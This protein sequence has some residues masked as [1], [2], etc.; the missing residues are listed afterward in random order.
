MTAP[1]ATEGTAVRKQ[2]TGAI[3]VW[4]ADGTPPA[5]DA[6]AYTW[7]GHA[8]GPGV[9]SLLKYVELHGDRL[10]GKYIS[11]IHDLGESGPMGER[12]IDRLALEGGLSYWWLTPFAEQS[13]YKMPIVDAVRLI[14]LDEIVRV[15]P[16]PNLR[17]FSNNA[18]LH[19]AIKRLCLDAGARYE[20]VRVQ[21]PRIPPR[22]R[23]VYRR[24]PEPVQALGVLVRLIHS[25]R[26]LRKASKKLQSPLNH[27]GV[28]FVSYFGNFSNRLQDRGRFQS[29]YWGGLVDLLAKHGIPSLWLEI[30]SKSAA[31][32]TP[33]VACNWLDG[34]NEKPAENGCHMFVESYFSWAAT[35]RVFAQWITLCWRGWRLDNLDE[36]CAKAGHRY[37][38]VLM[39][40]NWRRSLG[41]PDAISNLMALEV[42]CE[43]M[44]CLPHQGRGFYLCENQGWERALIH[45]W[46]KHGHGD[47]IGV[48][49][50]TV[51]FWDLRYFVDARTLN[52]ASQY[53]IPQPNALV[54]NGS[55]A[56]RALEHSGFPRARLIECEALRYEHLSQVSAGSTGARRHGSRREILVLGDYSEIV[57]AKMLRMLETYA[58]VDDRSHRCNY[59][60][61]PHPYS[62]IALDSFP[63][64][65]LKLVTEPL[66]RV[67][68]SYDVVLAANATS[69]AA[70]AYFAGLPIVV[71]LDPSDLNLSPLRGRG[72]VHFVSSNEELAGA[73]AETELN[74]PAA[75]TCHEFFCLDPL[76]PRWS[77]LLAS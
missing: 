63:S 9:R 54:V 59:S 38:W 48:V 32:P 56:A 2:A 5:D 58:A 13:F 25:W 21:W 46:R 77:R 75:D 53:S 40:P 51:R 47:L 7:N 14:A 26:G 4:D 23:A 28:F 41:G 24:L 20:W 12:L 36:R 44:R 33:R 22:L 29:Q 50:S 57:T 34:F 70:D 72:G 64:L 39:Q 10:R 11:W 30:F 61:K 60:I 65:G 15:H 3:I 19:G 69:A 31:T 66:G 6:H 17:L 45:A 62:G 74:P 73:L 35:G 1:N 76:L 49:H 8:D 55:A 27:G 16:R 67:L 43:A 37:L 52:I 18:H 71:M 42:F 68:D